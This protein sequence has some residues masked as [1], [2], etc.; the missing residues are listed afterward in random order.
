MRFPRYEPNTPD[1]T[2]GPRS[3]LHRVSAAI[4]TGKRPAPF[5]TRKLSPSAPMVLPGRPGGRVG[6]RR[7]PPPGWRS[8]PSPTPGAG[9]TTATH[10]LC[11][12]PHT[13]NHTHPVQPRS[14][15]EPPADTIE[16]RGMRLRDLGTGSKTCPSPDRGSTWWSLERPGI[17]RGT[18]T[19]AP[20]AG[21]TGQR[22]PGAPAAPPAAHVLRELAV[23]VGVV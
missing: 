19:P 12:P 4:A 1:T 21:G 10:A 3:H 2:R 7:T 14:R 23:A 18:T 20:L 11:H 15:G 13:S 8:S 17:D 6:R 9:R 5:R 22:I 16:R